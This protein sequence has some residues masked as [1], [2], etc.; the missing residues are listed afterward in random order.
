MQNLATLINNTQ[1]TA[2]IDDF[3]STGQNY[4]SKDLAQKGKDFFNK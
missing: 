3:L 1:N 2:S 4:D